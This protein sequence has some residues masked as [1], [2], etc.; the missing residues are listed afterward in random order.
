M[1]ASGETFWRFGPQHYP[2]PIQGDLMFENAHQNV[3]N[4]YACESL[5]ARDLPSGT[6]NCQH[7]Q[8]KM[9]RQL[10]MQTTVV[11]SND[12]PAL[13]LYIRGYDSSVLSRI[14]LLC[15]CQSQTYCARS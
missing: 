15:Y 6:I 1:T 9:E 10:F 11:S 3:H 13:L 12:D 7:V 14:T 8:Q 2:G 4:T 5:G